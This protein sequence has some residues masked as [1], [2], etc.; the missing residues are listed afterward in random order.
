MLGFSKKSKQKETDT[1]NASD[2]IE[3]DSKT[4]SEDGIE[5]ELSI[6]SEWKIANE[7]RYV[8]AFHNNE[9]PNLKI[10]QISIYGMELFEREGSFVA[11]GLIRNSVPKEV[12]FGS[13]PVLLLGPDK[14]VIA[15]REF[16]LSKLGNIPTNSARPWKF[17]FAGK[18]ILQDVDIPS[19][20]WSLAFEIKKK[21]QLDLEESWEK[22]I[23]DEAKANLE[24][25]IANA[26]PL[27]PG[28]MNF[29]GLE[30]KRN[31]NSD[32]VITI[33]I[34]NGSSKNVTL[35]Q[36]PLGVKDATGEEFAK[37][38]FQ[39]ENFTVKAN[40][41]KPWTFIFPASVITK[42]GIDLT[43]WKVYPLQ[44]E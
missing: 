31:K 3:A 41:S 20:D 25:I 36:V 14:Q 5:T 9:S 38:S 37:G 11:T 10:N 29:M 16:D 30:V 15:K 43:S 13:T 23:A 17:V 6:P 19:S 27:K 21:H 39:L 8:Y 7:E 22:S 24:K 42:E 28:E 34:R 18:N 4:T 40:T 35:Q 2:Y 33:L 44:G 32:L 1:A 26:N 12:K